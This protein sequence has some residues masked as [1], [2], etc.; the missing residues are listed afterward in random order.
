MRC[1]HGRIAER[2]HPCSAPVL[3]RDEARVG[4]LLLMV[5]QLAA[6]GWVDVVAKY[7]KEL[8]SLGSGFLCGLCKRT[9][10]RHADVVACFGAL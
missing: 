9:H 6:G 7:E 8:A 10:P 5:P 4:F 3:S 2:C 1:T